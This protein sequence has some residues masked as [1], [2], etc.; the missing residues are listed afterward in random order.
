MTKL[1]ARRFGSRW[2][3]T[4]KSDASGSSSVS[5]STVSVLASQRHCSSVRTQTPTLADP[6]LSRQKDILIEHYRSMRAHYGEGPGMRVARKHISWYS[7]GL[8]GS[9][10]FR[11]A[12]NRLAESAAV[13]A[14]IDAFFD[15]LIAAGAT[16]HI[17]PPEPEA[18]A[19]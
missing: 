12:V 1:T 3:V 17:L 15:P 11:A 8:P 5:S 4:S 16:R 2:R 19:A 10:E 6:P 13:E 14:L 18:L 9:A 7:R